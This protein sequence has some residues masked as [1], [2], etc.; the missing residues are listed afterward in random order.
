[1]LELLT[2]LREHNELDLGL[3]VY[4]MGGVCLYNF[5]SVYLASYREKLSE[6]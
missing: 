2:P 4:S 6:F 5:S 1:M 3:L